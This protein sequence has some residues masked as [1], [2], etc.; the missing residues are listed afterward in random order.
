MLKNCNE[1]KKFPKFFYLYLSEE[2]KISNR[3]PTD[4]VYLY[5]EYII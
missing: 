4:L 2:L 3:I 5:N 1:L